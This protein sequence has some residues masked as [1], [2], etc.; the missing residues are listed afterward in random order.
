MLARNERSTTHLH[1]ISHA[2]S[3]SPADQLPGPNTVK[4]GLT[5][6]RPRRL[7]ENDEYGAFLRRVA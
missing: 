1:V 2:A 5:S 7:V 4:D 3:T 6:K